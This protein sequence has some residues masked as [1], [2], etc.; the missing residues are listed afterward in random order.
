MT[1]MSASQMKKMN[2][3]HDRKACEKQTCTLLFSCPLCGFVI[4]SP[5]TAQQHFNTPAKKPVSVYRFGE[6]SAY[7]PSDWKPPR[8]C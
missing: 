1:D 3:Q 8:T 5:L 2:A 4:A 7:H 6:L